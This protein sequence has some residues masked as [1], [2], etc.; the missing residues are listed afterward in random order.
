MLFIIILGVAIL[1]L[2]INVVYKC[3]QMTNKM[4]QKLNYT[5]VYMTIFGKNE[6][7]I[8][9][10][11]NTCVEPRQLIL[12]KKRK[13]SPNINITLAT[14]IISFEECHLQTIDGDRICFSK[15]IKIPLLKY[16]RIRKI[17]NNLTEIQIHAEKKK[18]CATLF[19]WRLNMSDDIQSC[20]ESDTDLNHHNNN[21]NK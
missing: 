17:L 11:T 9:P 15:S 19:K 4:K 10:L 13:G 2:L 6:V 21:N 14:L 8:L 20:Y 16:Y 5:A 18:Q 12:F 1:F 3:Q 7:E